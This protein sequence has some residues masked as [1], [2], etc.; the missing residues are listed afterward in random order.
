MPN[1]YDGR[2]DYII[3]EYADPWMQQYSSDICRVAIDLAYLPR[4][5]AEEIEFHEE[6][7]FKLIANLRRKYVE[8]DDTMQTNHSS[9]EFINPKK[10]K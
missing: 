3:S 9:A 8:E 5:V 10:F 4:S 1:S 7:I 2:Q 6:S